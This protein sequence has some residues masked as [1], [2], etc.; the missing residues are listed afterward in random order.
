M[1]QNIKYFFGLNFTD[2]GGRIN[3]TRIGQW[4]GLLSQIII[5]YYSLYLIIFHAKDNL[6]RI[7]MLSIISAIPMIL[8]SIKSYAGKEGN[9]YERKDKEYSLR[10][11]SKMKSFLS[12][13]F[14]DG[15]SRINT[16]RIGQLSGVLAMVIFTI[17]ATYMVI[18]GTPEQLALLGEMNK[19]KLF[20]ANALTPMILYQLK[21][22]KGA[23]IENIIKTDI[24]T[25]STSNKNILIN[26][27]KGKTTIVGSTES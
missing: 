13:N 14:L 27:K 12:K 16:R 22:L 19:L 11:L 25:D 7:V 17:W 3:T 2:L 23:V 4:I 20:T 10:K 1:L 9:Q 21:D 5:T 6:E 26:I 18:F 15:Y 8:Y 24:K